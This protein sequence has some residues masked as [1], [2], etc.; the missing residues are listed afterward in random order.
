MTPSIYPSY[1]PSLTPSQASFL[2]STVKE[3][4]ICHGL[5]VAPAP[6]FIAA[7]HDPNH[8]LATTAPVTL[9]PSLVPL[10]CFHEALMIQT[11]YNEVYARI[12]R[13]EEWLGEVVEE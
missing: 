8:A 3:W 2:K 6:S 13:D 5:A 1:P 12:A 10:Q 4:A 7:E 9:F 11:A